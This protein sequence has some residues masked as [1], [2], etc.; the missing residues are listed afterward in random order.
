MAKEYEIK[1]TDNITENVNI[2]LYKAGTKVKDIA[3]STA[4]DLSHLWT[5]S[6]SLVAGNDY[7][8]R[9]SS[10]INS[11]VYAE[12]G[13]ITISE[14]VI[15]IDGNV[16][17]TVSIG[18]QIWMKENLKTTR[19]RNGDFI[20]T[21]SP[22][23]LDI[24]GESS[25]KYQWPPNDS[26]S[27]VNI[28]GRLYTWYAATD[29]RGM[30]PAG[31]HLPSDSEWKFLEIA[32]GMNSTEADNSDWRGSNEGSKLAGFSALAIWSDG[33][34]KSN[35][36]FGTSGF[37]ALPAGDHHDTGQ[38]GGLGWGSW[39]TS[40][41]HSSPLAWYRYINASSSKIVRSGQLIGFGLSIRCVKD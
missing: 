17:G 20:G 2:E 37:I 8:I 28:Y 18:T 41:Y 34:L 10:T 16:Y 13:V 19:Y 5:V 30:C 14:S 21:T 38:M 35:S 31:W 6:S 15:D 23:N 25:P 36:A 40:T 26:E 39:W 1:W 9:I 27:N 29:N 4:N 7:K 11:S 12:S 22:V 33:L 24:S 32:I 3:V